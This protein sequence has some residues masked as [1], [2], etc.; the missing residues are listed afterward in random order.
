[1]GRKKGM[2]D[3]FRVLILVLFNYFVVVFKFV[4]WFMFIDCFF[5]V[6]YFLIVEMNDGSVVVVM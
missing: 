4:N 1:M 3:K 6:Y 2:G 5:D